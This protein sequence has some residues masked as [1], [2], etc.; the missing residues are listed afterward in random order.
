MATRSLRLILPVFTALGVACGG[1]LGVEPEPQVFTSLAVTSTDTTLVTVAPGNTLQLTI[2]AYNQ[3]GAVMP[4]GPATWSSSAPEIA[5]VSS[6]GLVTAAA[7]G[8]AE[9][10]AAFT[11]GGKSRT[12][13]MRVTVYGI[14]LT[15]I[16]G[17]YD[18]TALITY[19]SPAWDDL[20][21]YRFT[22]VLTLHEERDEPW[23]GGTYTDWQLI[24]P[25][26]N[27]GAVAGTGF[28]TVGFDSRGR[29]IIELLG[30]R[31]N[32][33]LTLIPDMMALGIIEGGFVC[34]SH[35]GGRFTAT[36]RQR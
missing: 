32:L 19:S 6:S 16:A 26:G 20:R 35:F 21:G 7:P 22:A 31:N 8:R 3:A 14:D 30:D 1:D 18:L 17:V 27:S 33:D 29:L 15:D 28:V 25:G 4:A 10:K 2:V 36:R 5:T 23:V 13:S 34:C 24:D 9:I 12:A 11:L